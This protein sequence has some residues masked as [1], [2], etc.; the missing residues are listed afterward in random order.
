MG[1][2]SKVIK[3]AQKVLK[4][5]KPAG[6]E[7]EEEEDATGSEDLGDDDSDDGDL[8]SDTYSLKAPERKS[9]DESDDDDDSG[10]HSSSSPPPD[11]EESESSISDN[12]FHNSATSTKSTGLCLKT[13]L[14]FQRPAITA[15][16]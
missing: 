4:A 15:G 13:S 10:D 6:E 14:A 11:Q 3:E 8:F 1:A 12:L 9:A 7:E 5:I 16:K 2:T